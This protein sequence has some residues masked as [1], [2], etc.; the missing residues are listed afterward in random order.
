MELTE[1]RPAYV[2]FEMRAVEDRA[3]TI[4]N[5]YYSTKD[6]EFAL[7]TPPYSKDCVEMECGVWLKKN[8][9]DERNGRIPSTW[10]DKWKLAY[11]AWKNGQELPLD[12]YPIKGW[13]VLSPSQQANLLAVGI[14]TVQD[15]A[16]VNDEGLKRIG[17]GSV[18]LK[19]RATAWLKAESG[20]GKLAQENAALKVKVDSQDEQIKQLAATVDELKAMLPKSQER[21]RVAA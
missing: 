18:D 20:P 9:D 14:K 13:G 12:G 4:T 19:N 1:E 2:M 11:D 17:M 5:G 6:V 10:R 3:A 8:D 21:N 15:L 16:K 7:I